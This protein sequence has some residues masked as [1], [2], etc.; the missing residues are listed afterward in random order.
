M[1][2]IP[3]FYLLIDHEGRAF[4]RSKKAPNYQLKWYDPDGIYNF[5]TYG[6]AVALKQVQG[7]KIQLLFILDNEDMDRG[8]LGIQTYQEQP[9]PYKD[10]VT[11]F[12][13]AIGNKKFEWTLND[14]FSWNAVKV[15]EQIQ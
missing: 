3:Q 1:G 13:Y 11:N 10:P 4:L 6:L 12:N 14:D 7:N 8:R 15:N 5:Y 9:D 2:K